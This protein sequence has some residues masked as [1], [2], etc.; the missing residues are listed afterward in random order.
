MKLSR[1]SRPRAG[2]TVVLAKVSS[3]LLRGLPRSDKKAICEI[4]GKSVLLVEY[5][6]AGRAELKF[7]DS[8]GEIHFIYVK[9]GFI[10]PAE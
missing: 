7:R 2:A 9:P 4:V 10:R 3:G 6:D 5:D 1:N 8:H